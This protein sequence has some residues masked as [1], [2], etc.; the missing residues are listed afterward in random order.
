MKTAVIAHSNDVFSRFR[1]LNDSYDYLVKP[2]IAGEKELTMHGGIWMFRYLAL[3]YY[4]A[5]ND[6]YEFF[7]A[8]ILEHLQK[9]YDYKYTRTDHVRL[10][11]SNISEIISCLESMPLN[12]PPEILR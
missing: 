7:K 5:P 2:I 6:E 1:T 3:A 8:A 9:L 12:I 10:Y 4:V 11:C